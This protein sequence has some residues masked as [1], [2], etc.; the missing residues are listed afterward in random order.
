MASLI[1]AWASGVAWGWSCNDAGAETVMTLNSL[2]A[3][4]PMAVCNDGSPAGYYFSPGAAES[5][6]FLVYL[7]GGG[8]CYDEASCVARGNGSQYPHHD[9]AASNE[10]KP[11]FLS[12]KDYGPTCNKTGIFSA[13]ASANLP[14]HDAHKAYLPY[15]S[16]DAHMGDGAAF[17][18]EFRGQRIVRAMLADLNAR[19][20]MGAGARVVFGGGSAGGRGA[21]VHLDAVAEALAAEPFSAAEVVGFLDSPFYV[22]EAPYPPAHFV[23]FP[24]EMAEAYAHFNASAVAGAPCAAAHGDEPWKCLFGQYRMPFLETPYLM[25]ASQFDGWQISNEVLGYNGI[26]PEPTLDAAELAYV[27]ALANDTL[28]LVSAL[29]TKKVSDPKSSIFSIAC[30]SHH[31]SEKT[32]FATEKTDT[33]ISQADALFWFLEPSI[34]TSLK[35]IDDSTIAGFRMCASA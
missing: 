35:Y 5:T 18:M 28:S 4:D 9:C 31:V 20:G 10:S 32:K 26:V 23:G 17:G 15:C 14:L 21:M 3:V 29:P 16:S 30:Y 12:S 7:A 11:C 33:N 27:D 6:T 22:D 8:Q 19:H 34:T 2:A 13:E 1:F 24:A 25:V